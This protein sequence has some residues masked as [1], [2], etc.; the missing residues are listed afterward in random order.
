M[1]RHV[2]KQGEYLAELAYRHR[3][4]EADVWDDPANA[5][6]KEKR[7]NPQILAPGDV[8]HVPEKK[9]QPVA[10]TVGGNNSYR[11]EVPM[12]VVI[13]GFVKEGQPWAGEPFEIESLGVKGETDAEGRLMISAPVTTREVLVL[14]P[15]RCE[16]YAVRIGDLDPISEPSGVR[17]RLGHL[18][19]HGW[20][21]AG[22]GEAPGEHDP[23]WDALMI[24]A[25][26]R[27]EGLLPASG[28]MDDPTR[29]RL[30]ARHGV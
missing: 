8:L 15:R 2:I 14:F 10:L 25:F 26:Q 18:G 12:G 20:L 22:L 1:K 23:A 7:P 3:F 21:L 24:A 13:L 30:L 11:A 6:L 9:R 19:H 4:D 5:E 17:Q 29:D 16:Y 28:E 27:A